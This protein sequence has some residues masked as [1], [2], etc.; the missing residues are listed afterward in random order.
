MGGGSQTKKELVEVGGRAIL[1]H[2]M[3]IFAAYGHTHFILTLGHM[4]AEIK[5]YFLDLNTIT[6]DL[7][8][9]LGTENRISFHTSPQEAGW[10]ITLADTGL[11]TNKGSR[12][13]Q[14]ARYLGAVD[15]F[16]VTYGDGV[17]DVDIDALLAFHLAHD[18]S[19]TITGVNPRSQYGIAKVDSAGRV[20]GF[21]EK[22][23]LEHWI[24]GGFM[25][26]RGEALK[27]LR[28]DDVDLETDAL[29]R[30]AADGEL[31]MYRHT[32]FWRSMDTFKE[33][34]ELDTIW[35]DQTP[36]KVW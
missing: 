17:G 21:E 35:R 26:F 7:T 31:M 33:A 24:N 36:W 28:G 23:R 16:F 9:T 1:W 11:Q 29:V 19:A 12:I 20:S 34:R 8:L 6:H 15:H 27:Y 10:K 13:Y 14:A 22:P 3:R 18:K 2:V 4:A 25:V 30:L 32:G 5:R